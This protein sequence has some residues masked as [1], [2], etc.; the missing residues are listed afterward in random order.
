MIMT[1][2]PSMGDGEATAKG[3]R[4]FPNILAHRANLVARVYDMDD[5]ARISVT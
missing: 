5:A 2:P 4:N 1:E 3:N